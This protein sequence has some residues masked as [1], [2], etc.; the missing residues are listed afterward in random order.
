MSLSTDFRYEKCEVIPQTTAV[1][2]KDRESTQEP[3][4]LCDIKRRLLK[5]TDWA[6]VSAAR[7]LKMAF[8]PVEE[9]ARFGKRRKLTEADRRRL[10][11]T[12]TS[13]TTPEFGSYYGDRKRKRAA[14]ETDPIEGL[15]IKVNAHRPDTKQSK[16]TRNSVSQNES[17]Q[18]ML[19]DRDYYGAN[20]SS[21]QAGRRATSSRRSVLTNQRYFIGSSNYAPYSTLEPSIAS[22]YSNGR[23]TARR[24]ESL[25]PGYQYSGE[26]RGSPK[27]SSHGLPFQQ[28]ESSIPAPRR[29]T[30][31]DQVLAEKESMFGIGSDAFGQ[32][33][34]RS[35]SSAKGRKPSKAASST[36]SS[37]LP[38]QE[39]ARQSELNFISPDDEYSSS[40][41]CSSWLPKPRYSIQRPLRTNTVRNSWIPFSDTTTSHHPLGNT[42]SFV[43][44]QQ[45]SPMS[46]RREI[47]ETPVEMYGRPMDF[48]DENFDEQARQ[49][50]P[51]SASFDLEE[52]QPTEEG[53][54][55]W[56][57]PLAN[58]VECEINSKELNNQRR[59]ASLSS[60]SQQL[61]LDTD[62]HSNRFLDSTR[63]SDNQASDKKSVSTTM[64]RMSSTQQKS[65]KTSKSY[66]ENSGE[67][68]N[69]YINKATIYGQTLSSPI[70]PRHIKESQ[71]RSSSYT[72]PEPLLSQENEAPTSP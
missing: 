17:S 13:L 58:G 1:N 24:M 43:S 42:S 20:P 8:T 54:A 70:S 26:T 10:A 31:D 48:S 16:R 33:S 71:A 11:S 3:A 25:R 15:D 34:E 9:L 2:T 63:M 14:S 29:F 22:P 59:H 7:P 61:P 27:P 52:N 4:S 39:Q 51:G 49:F 56:G 68:C 46:P 37:Y 45:T 50:F 57:Q 32:Q 18:S 62:S 36:H 30:I 72:S 35:M 6:A 69:S 66:P 12:N 64:S 65:S 47:P 19:L 23:N 28:S 44:Q 38:A 41:Q 5:E 67:S 21:S 55:V 53:Y 40:N 60:S